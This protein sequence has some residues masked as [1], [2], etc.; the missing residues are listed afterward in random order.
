MNRHSSAETEREI[1]RIVAL[2]L[3]AYEAVKISLRTPFRLVSGNYS[4]IYIN[5]RKLISFPA[6]IELF[7]AAAREII[8]NNGIDIDGIAGGETA[9]IPFA[10]FLAVSLN[11]PLVYVRKKAKE[12]GIANRIEGTAVRDWQMLLVEDLITD[13]GSK[14]DFIEALTMAGAS[15]RDVLVIFDRLQGG[16]AALKK[17]GVRLHAITDMKMVL[18][19]AEDTNLIKTAALRSVRNYIASPARWH[20]IHGLPYSRK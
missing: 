13:A 8:R 9:G 12:H 20:A 17:R 2:Q 1:R 16:G 11:K 4:P 7:R 14:L 10:A 3:W 5:C 19:V 18:S 15:V 6:F